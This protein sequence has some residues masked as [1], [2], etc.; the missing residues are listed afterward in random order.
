MTAKSLLDQ[1]NSNLIKNNLKKQIA[2]HLNV[3]KRKN[4]DNKSAS[5]IKIAA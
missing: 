5:I 1:S 3:L 4:S 2:P